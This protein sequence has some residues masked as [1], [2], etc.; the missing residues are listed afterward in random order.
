MSY[1]RII[2][3][4]NAGK[5]PEMRHTKEGKAVCNFSVAVNE[6][7]DEKPTWFTV[8]CWEKLAEI[9]TEH[10][11]KGTQVLVEGRLQI[12]EYEGK[13][14]KGTAVEVVANNVRL[15]G[16]KKDSAPRTAAVPASVA[17]DDVPF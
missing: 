14:G 8:V 4:G 5:D 6:R 3:V 13:N 12:R 2:I 1:Q 10:V 17:S 9:C 15:L 11:N 7:K 16:S